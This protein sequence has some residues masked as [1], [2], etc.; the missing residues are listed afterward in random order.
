MKFSSFF[1]F[2][3]NENI[4]YEVIE[5]NDFYAIVN[6]TEDNWTAGKFI[7]YSSKWEVDN[8]ADTLEEAIKWAKWVEGLNSKN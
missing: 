2:L 5:Q 6:V 4:A 1:D 8:E 3:K 7:A